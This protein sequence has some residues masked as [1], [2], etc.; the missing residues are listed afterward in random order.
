MALSLVLII[1]YWKLCSGVVLSVEELAQNQSNI[2]VSDSATC[3]G[4]WFT[5]TI[6]GTCHCGAAVS[7][8]VGLEQQLKHPVLFGTYTTS[9]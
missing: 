3:I 7:G 6:N 1:V 2:S 5:A 9:E 4:P 8:A